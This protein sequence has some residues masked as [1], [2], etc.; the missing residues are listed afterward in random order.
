MGK[1]CA[2]LVFVISQHNNTAHGKEKG[3]GDVLEQ[4]AGMQR[5]KQNESD[6]YHHRSGQ[7]GEL[8]G[9]LFNV[10]G[11]RGYVCTNL[12]NLFRWQL[13][14]E[15]VDVRLDEG[16]DGVHGRVAGRTCLSTVLWQ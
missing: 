8:V 16:L 4:E 10:K 9:Q 15:V 3:N 7:A 13:C 14:L 11:Q 12:G 5:C 1:R 6:K 2:L